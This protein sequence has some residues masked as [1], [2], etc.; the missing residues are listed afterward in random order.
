MDIACAAAALAEVA[1]AVEARALGCSK[2]K[3]SSPNSLFRFDNRQ[4]LFHTESRK[5]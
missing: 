2:A 5:P 1:P 3:A 4:L